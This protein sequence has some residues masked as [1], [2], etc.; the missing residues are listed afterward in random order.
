MNI[1]L[2]P[3]LLT[4]A[5]LL[6]MPDDGMDRDLIRGR[7]KERLMVLR[8]R[9]EGR[10]LSKLARVF[11]NWLD[12]QPTPRG[13]VLIDAGFRVRK[14]P[15]T[16]YGIDLAYVSPELAAATPDNAALIDGTPV[17]AIEILSPS[18]KHEDITEKVTEYLT[19]GVPLVWVV[20]PDF[21]TVRVHRP[22]DEPVLVNRRQELSGEP[23]LP[24][25]RVAVAALFP[26]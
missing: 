17:L 1:P 13:E 11:G 6:A 16:T 23:E 21:R 9:R 24:G 18:D 10:L 8:N 5:D 15:D 26:P 14:D 19:V 2:T 22:G 12:Q 3:P 20:D 4:T 25:F 7:L